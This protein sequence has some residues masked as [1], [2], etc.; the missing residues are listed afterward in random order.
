MAPFT[1]P[2]SIHKLLVSITLVVLAGMIT[3]SNPPASSG[4]ALDALGPVCI[5]MMVARVHN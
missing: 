2:T 5:A 3:G 4:G 1:N